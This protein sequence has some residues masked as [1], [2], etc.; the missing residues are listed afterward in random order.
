MTEVTRLRLSKPQSRVY[1]S[2][3]RFRVVVA[4]RRFGKTFL[5][6]VYLLQAAGE[7]GSICWY[8]APTYRQAKQIAWKLLK[9][10]LALNLD[11]LK[12]N[13]TDLTIEFQNGS[14]IS[15]RGADN[16]DS[17][18]GVSLNA[19]VLDEYADMDEA[20]WSEV[21]RP[22][23]ADKM[24]SALFIG[25]PKG[26]NHFY[27]LWSAA[28]SREN[29]AAWSFTTAQ[30][31]NVAIEEIE[32]ARAELDPRTFK[33]EFEASFE[34]LT[35]RVYQHFERATHVRGDLEDNGGPLLIGMDFNISPM[36]A[37]VGVR[38]GDQLHILDAIEIP[39]GNTELMAKEILRRYPG[40]RVQVYPDASGQSR[41]TSAPSGIT[42]HVLLRQAG[43]TVV[44]PP[45]NPLVVDRVNEV[46]ALFRNAEGVV[47]CYVAAKC[48]P[49][50]KCLEGL[51]Y[52]DGTSIP[53][54][55]LGLD[56]LPDALGYLVHSEFPILTRTPA[57][58][59]FRIG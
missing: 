52:K 56:H 19:C 10:L 40:R 53:D 21:I 32:A 55:G 18:R 29:W 33:Q 20:A 57:A 51:T 45:S 7:P 17:L 30:G 38:A 15:L 44:A 25:T 14:E 12:V 46:N 23:L 4:G 42:D 58:N 47:R 50:I 28:H 49:L 43:F 27:D 2:G 26:F 54:K 22:A 9:R 35:G 48:A 31:G 59:H 11:G 1:R 5:A 6:L 16:P 39:N 37:V 3:A 36:S 24:G 41:R 34:A 13:E 8:I